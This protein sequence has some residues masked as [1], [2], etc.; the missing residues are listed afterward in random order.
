MNKK[1][2]LFLLQLICHAALVWA[3]FN[4]DLANWLACILIYF[5]LSCLGG[6]IT[7]HRYFSHKAFEFRYKWLERLFTLFA[8]YSLSGD[9]MSWVNNHRQHHRATDKPG[10]PHSPA[11]W[12]FWRVQ[13][14]SMFTSYDRLRFVPNMARDQFLVNIHHYYYKF[15]WTFLI[16][17]ALIDWKLA[18]AVYLVPSA[19]VWIMG[20]FINTI[21]H[22]VGYRNHKTNDNSTN[23]VLLGYTVWGEGWHNNHHANP[24]AAKFGQRWWEF[25]IS[26]QV[27]RLISK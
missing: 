12:G 18:C 25:D 27:I 22:T 4:F 11:I 3:L 21:S 9:P 26:Y 1:L 13:F 7:L 2:Q 16:L 8:A 14:G 23:N 17:F 6:S 24:G 10:D 5:V 15:H 19:L 20:S